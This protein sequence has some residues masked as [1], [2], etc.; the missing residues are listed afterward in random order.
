MHGSFIYVLFHILR[1]S[2]KKV[3]LFVH[4][5]QPLM[6]DSTLSLSLSLSLSIPLHYIHVTRGQ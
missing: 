5:L 4:V 1:A 6:S 2:E 3:Y